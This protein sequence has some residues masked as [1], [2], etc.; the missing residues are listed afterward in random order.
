MKNIFIS[1]LFL[2]TI[3]GCSKKSE[4]PSSKVNEIN[5]GEPT[6]PAF[7]YEITEVLRS[8]YHENGIMSV[9]G[10]T[11]VSPDDIYLLDSKSCTVFHTDANLNIINKFGGKG[12][13][14]GEFEVSYNIA[15][16][17]DT[18]SIIDDQLRRISFFDRDGNFI[19]SAGFSGSISWIRY[20]GGKMIGLGV[21]N[22]T[23]DEKYYGIQSINIYDSEINKIASILERRNYIKN[24]S[25]SVLK[26]IITA[27]GKDRIHLYEK[28]KKDISILVYD[29]DG[30]LIQTIKDRAP[31]VDIS[32]EEIKELTEKYKNYNLAPDVIDE[33]IFGEGK[34]KNTVKNIY[35]DK[36]GIL[37]VLKTYKN[38]GKENPVYSI[39]KFGVY[40]KDITI[41]IPMDHKLFFEK[42]RI[43]AVTDQYIIVYD[44]TEI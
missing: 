17:S 28:S 8:D 3:A 24:P 43:Y 44:Y 7:Q 30:K 34:S 38:E 15:A 13:G 10:I 37:W 16:V 41:P 25:V 31:I 35:A 27:I 6:D 18:V 14:P 4:N 42:D 23:V 9:K 32:A 39:Y 26:L 20:A 5:N 1:F 2:I 40:L 19:R 36:N 12:Q 29:L 11:A 22:E 21:S 33:I